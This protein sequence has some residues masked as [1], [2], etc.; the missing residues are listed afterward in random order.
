MGTGPD[1][2]VRGGY[3]VLHGGVP[4][5]EHYGVLAAFGMRGGLDDLQ[6]HGQLVGRVA[7]AGEGQDYVAALVD[8]LPLGLQRDRRLVV[9]DDSV[10]DEVGYA[11]LEG[12]IDGV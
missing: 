7:V 3:G 4:R 11:V 10:M 9:F 1:V 2:I 12:G 5:R 8:G 6:P